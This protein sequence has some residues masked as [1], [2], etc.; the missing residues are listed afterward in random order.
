M[1]DSSKPYTTFTGMLSILYFLEL[2]FSCVRSLLR[3]GTMML[4]LY[5]ELLCPIMSYELFSYIMGPAE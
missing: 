5:C 2:C 1:V 4:E 3:S